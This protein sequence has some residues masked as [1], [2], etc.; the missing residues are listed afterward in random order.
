MRLNINNHI[1]NIVSAS[2]GIIALL[3]FF[4]PYGSTGFWSIYLWCGISDMID[5]KLARYLHVESKT[6]AMIDSISDLIFII[7]VAISIL[8]NIEFSLWILMSIGMI[9]FI[10]IF[11]IVNAFF[12][13]GRVVMLHTY[14]NKLTG[15][16]L[17]ILP[18]SLIWF[19][20]TYPAIIVIITAL[21]ASLQEGYNIFSGHIR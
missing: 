2:R 14:A 21:F 13:Y 10:R 17:F 8:P 11:N 18:V 5:G 6:G 1:P 20:V 12:R 7:T 3:L 9:A 19:P 4:F 16:L 15:L